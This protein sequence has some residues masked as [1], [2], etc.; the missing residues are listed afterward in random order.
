MWQIN[1]AFTGW[2][3]WWHILPILS[4]LQTIDKN[5]QYR[6]V[7]DNIY[8]FGEKRGMEY[9]F[10]TQ[11]QDSYKNI[12]PQFVAIRSGKYRRETLRISR[13]RNVRDMFLFPFWI[14]QSIRYILTKR[15][16]LVF[17]KWGYVALPV[18][19]AAWI[20]RRKIYVH[21]SDTSSWLTT[22]IASRF[23]TQNFSAFPHTLKN[24][25]LVWQILSDQLI[26]PLEN[27]QISLPEDKYIVLVAGW[28]SWSRKLYQAV[29]EAINKHKNHFSSHY[30]V[31]INGQHLI[32]SSLD[33]VLITDLVKDQSQMGYLY[34]KSDFAIVRWW[35]TTLAEAKLFELPLAIVPLPITHDQYNNADYYVK[36]Y[37]DLLIDQR[38]E[39][40]VDQLY[41]SLVSVMKKAISI[42][43]DKIKINI[44]EAK[45]VILDRMMSD[46]SS[47]RKQN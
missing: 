21:E 35:T 1:I 40:F 20:C 12:A 6:Q 13:W 42:S 43:T 28:S 45:T 22:R 34:R 32:Q 47:P 15:I 4:L 14:I 37:G 27:A 38:S 26:A 24:T 18:V 5:R 41:N 44:N 7:I 23:A 36:T 16:D 29:L 9:E 2:W 17:C 3:T 39:D 30:F 31:F 19:I 46:I 8:R 10:Y 25:R 11:S 33:N